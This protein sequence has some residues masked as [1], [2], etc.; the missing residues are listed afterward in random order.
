MTTVCSKAGRKRLIDHWIHVCKLEEEG[1]DPEP[2]MFATEVEAKQYAKNVGQGLALFA[3]WVEEIA[4]F[5]VRR[6]VGGLAN[7]LIDYSD[8]IVRDADFSEVAAEEYLD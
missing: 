4:L 5:K 3:N 6:D 7:R 8:K 1:Y 2:A